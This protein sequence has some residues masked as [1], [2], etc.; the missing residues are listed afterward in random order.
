MLCIV[1]SFVSTIYSHLDKLQQIWRRILRNLTRYWQNEMI[2]LLFREEYKTCLKLLYF[3]QAKWQMLATRK[4]TPENI[5]RLHR[6]SFILLAIV[7]WYRWRPCICVTYVLLIF[8][9]KEVLKWIH[10]LWLIWCFQTL[11]NKNYNT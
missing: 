9:C 1:K 4:K 10:K 8:S 7:I 6:W 11:I 2:M 3:Q 5:I